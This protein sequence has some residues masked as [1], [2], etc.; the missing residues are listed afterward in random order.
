MRKKLPKIFQKEKKM[1]SVG[2]E[3]LERRSITDVRNKFSMLK[4]QS[5]LV[6]I[7]EEKE[8]EPEKSIPEE[9]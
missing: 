1:E 7:S 8:K 4:T 6:K 9:I 5:K 3:R 2:L